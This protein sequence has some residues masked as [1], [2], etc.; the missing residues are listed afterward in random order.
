MLKF[1]NSYGRFNPLTTKD[2]WFRDVDN[3]AIYSKNADIFQ[4]IYD[5]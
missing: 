4:I 2:K 5:K 3:I 1:K